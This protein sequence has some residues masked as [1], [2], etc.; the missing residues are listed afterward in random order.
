[1]VPVWFQF[2]V[3]VP[4][5]GLKAEGWGWWVSNRDL[6]RVNLASASATL[7]DWPPPLVVK[8]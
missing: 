4:D 6:K 3:G 5:L 1:M 8:R 7:N 2:T